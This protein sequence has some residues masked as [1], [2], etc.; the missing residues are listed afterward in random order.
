MGWRN[1]YC[2][3]SE[4][5]TCLI[6]ISSLLKAHGANNSKCDNEL[7]RPRGSNCMHHGIGESNFEYGELDNTK[8]SWIVAMLELTNVSK[9]LYYKND[10][11]KT[12]RLCMKQ[13]EDTKQELKE[14]LVGLR[15][16]MEGQKVKFGKARN[17]IHAIEI[18]LFK[19]K[20]NNNMFGH[21]LGDYLE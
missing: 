18:T 7:G 10:I 19:C 17:N 20:D 14:W 2:Y 12:I 4:K 6:N 21:H 9:L 8:T 13:L 1:L 16:N 3:Y 11:K 5:K 15:Y